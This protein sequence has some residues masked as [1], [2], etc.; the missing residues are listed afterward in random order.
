M[1]RCVLGVIHQLELTYMTCLY[2]T[3][4]QNEQTYMP[5]DKQVL[6]TRN[7]FYSIGGVR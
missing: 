3:K 4:E 1:E 5:T 7:P 6:E 2:Q